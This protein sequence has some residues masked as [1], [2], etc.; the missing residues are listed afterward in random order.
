MPETKLKPCPFCGGT[1]ISVRAYSIC[2]ECYIECNECNAN[3]S[4]EV[5]W[6]NMTEEEHDKKCYEKL[7]ELWNRRT[8]NE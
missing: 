2:T 8:D 1:D 5:N 4:S 6:E 7:A 3:I